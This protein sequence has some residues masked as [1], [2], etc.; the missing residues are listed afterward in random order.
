[1]GIR[2]RDGSDRSK[3]SPF[4]SE[5]I[6]ATVGASS[7]QGLLGR[8]IGHARAGDRRFL[9]GAPIAIAIGFV[10]GENI[11]I[12]RSLSPIFNLVLSVPQSIFLPV[13]VLVFGLGFTEKL[14]FGITHVVFV[15]AVNAM[16]AVRE[17]PHGQVVLARSSVPAS[18]GYTDRSTC[19]QW[20][21][22]RDRASAWHD[23]RH[24]RHFARRNVRFAKWSGR[25]LLRWGKSYDVNK[26]MA[27]TVLISVVTILINEI[28]RIW[29]A[30]IG[31]WRQVV[32]EPMTSTM[33]IVIETRG[34]AQSLQLDRAPI[35]AL[36]EISFAVREGSFVSLVG[37]SG[38]GKSTL[39]QMLAGLMPST[40]GEVFVDGSPVRKPVPD[41]ISVMFQDATLLP[42]KSVSENIEF[43][44]EIQWHIRRQTG[45]NARQ[46]CCRLSGLRNS[47]PGI[48]MNCPGACGNAI[49]DRARAGAGSEDPAHGRAVRRA[50]RTDAHQDGS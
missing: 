10:M 7:E 19:R 16:A 37:P 3:A 40:S 32:E 26:L 31:R 43:P 6:V 41:K 47:P 35:T 13:F 1:M 39:L 17:V 9:I 11:G 21:P 20:R 5:V 36:Q 8:R 4:T 27:A 23:L 42:W 29:E 15:V 46:R 45:A 22:G 33:P 28:M 14:I 38:C 44:L 24:H 2:R 50:R 34:V 30:R 48:R 18:S 25:L 49:A 12:G